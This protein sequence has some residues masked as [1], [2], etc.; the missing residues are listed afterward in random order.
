MSKRKRSENGQS[1]ILVALLLVVF[2]G[3]LALVLDGGY[4]Y[5][6]RRN[7]QNAADAGA[8][9]GARVYCEYL[10]SNIE[11]GKV[12]GRDKALEYVHANDA[13]VY[14]NDSTIDIAISGN[15]VTVE[16]KIE[17]DN[18]FGR[19]FGRNT[20]QAVAHAA[21]GCYS[22]TAAEGV[23][24]IVWFCQPPV[25]PD[26]ATSKDCEL[27]W[28]TDPV[29]QQYLKNPPMPKCDPIC[30]E[31]YIIWD[32]LK[33]PPDIEDPCELYLKCDLDNDEELDYKGDGGRAW[34]DLDGKASQYP[35]PSEAINCVP[36]GAEGDPEQKYWVDIGYECEI[37]PHTWIPEEYGVGMDIA[38]EVE[39][40]RIKNPY[41]ILPVFDE[42]CE[43]D[44]PWLDLRCKDLTPPAWHPDEDQ[45]RY[46]S[47]TYFHLKAFS[48]F[49]ITCVQGKTP[50]G[51]CP[52]YSRFAELNDKKNGGN[53]AGTESIKTIEGYFLTGYIPGLEGRGDPTE[54][55][56][57]TVY[58]DE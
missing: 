9:A 40:R 22:P 25:D 13:L 29:L 2:I 51:D 28:I 52:G 46:D 19:I 20:S 16:T 36:T 35:D 31:L 56:V 49:Y 45:M 50:G 39:A 38:K 24:P 17:F 37:E 14:P 27:Q 21:A 10:N 43:D 54:T 12:L 42:Y 32:S 7:A 5:F 48:V 57:F 44:L 3:I 53:I 6:M 33:I 30:P 26:L 18:F 34:A 15:K 8:L 23:L 11:Q 58:L 4:T 55:G 1:L 41:V 47:P